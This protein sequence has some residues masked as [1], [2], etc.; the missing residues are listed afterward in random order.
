MWRGEE[1]E[2]S[3][4]WRHAAGCVCVECLNLR[5]LLR[6]QAA[7]TMRAVLSRFGGHLPPVVVTRIDD[8]ADALETADLCDEHPQL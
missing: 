2:V 1:A 6:R 3:A 5:E 8:V 4:F 7:A